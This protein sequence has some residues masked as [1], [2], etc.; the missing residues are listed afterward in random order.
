GPRRTAD[1]RRVLGG[2]EAL[3]R[4]PAR[5]RADRYAREQQ[6]AL[7][8]APGAR[9]GGVP[10]QGERRSLQ[11]GGGDA[12]AGGGVMSRGRFVWLLETP[13]HCRWCGCTSDHPCPGLC[14]WANRAET[15]CT[16]CV[17]LDRALQSVR[18]RR[19][20]AEFCQEYEFLARAG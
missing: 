19:E 3:Q 15:L 10:D 8:R 12:R 18:G 5:A 13:G 9:R 16:R 14:G 7:G 11:G 1:R 4:D 17:P 2:L 6:I 20:L